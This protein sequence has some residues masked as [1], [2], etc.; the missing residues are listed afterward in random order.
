VLDKTE[1]I[2]IK[3]KKAFEPPLPPDKEASKDG[4]Y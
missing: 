3:S 4:I 1:L 2:S